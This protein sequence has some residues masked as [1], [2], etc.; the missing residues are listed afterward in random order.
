[1]IIDKLL[2]YDDALEFFLNH[3]NKRIAKT[4][5]FDIK[6]E[7]EIEIYTPDSSLRLP[8]DYEKKPLSV[9]NTPSKEFVIFLTHF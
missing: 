1:M 7:K 6:P 3:V 2:V 4:V 5:A 8:E 9:N